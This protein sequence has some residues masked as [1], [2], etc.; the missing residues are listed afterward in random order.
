MS[1]WRPNL[2]EGGHD[3]ATVSAR[4]ET[5]ENLSVGAAC[6]AS[7]LG[8]DSRGVRRGEG[9]SSFIADELACLPAL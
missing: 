6:F 2:R 1:R 9:G 3:D 7:D 4:A 5:T 8:L